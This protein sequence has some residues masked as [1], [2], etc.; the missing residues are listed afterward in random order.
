M[1]PAIHPFSWDARLAEAG[2]ILH[3]GRLPYTWLLPP[4]GGARTTQVVDR[5]Y[6]EGWPLVLWAVFVWQVAADRRPRTQ[7]LFTFAAAWIVLGT[8]I[9]IIMSS[10]GPVY[11]AHVVHGPDVYAPLLAHHAAV[12]ATHPLI[13]R[14]IQDFLWRSERLGIASGGSGISA[15]PSMHVAMAELCAIAGRNSGRRLLAIGLTIFSIAILVGSVYLGPHYALDGYVSIV[16][17]HVLWAC[18]RRIY[19]RAEPKLVRCDT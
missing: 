4:L 6:Y 16:G 13:G 14:R 10:A 3:G 19:P 15:M 17:I 8:L 9:A 18:A 11:Y 5:L 7:F 1:L 12:D 2:R